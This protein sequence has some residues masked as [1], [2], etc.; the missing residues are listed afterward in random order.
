MMEKSQQNE[1]Q[2]SAESP[3]VAKKKRS[4]WRRFLRA[5]AHLSLGMLALILFIIIM[6]WVLL[7]TNPGLNGIIWTAEK[8]VPELKVED[9]E[10]ALLNDFQLYGI[11]YNNPD[12]FVA[13]QAEKLELDIQLRCIP[14]VELCI[15]TLGIE[16][17]NFALTDI[18]PS[19]EVA[20]EPPSEPI[21]SVSLPFGLGVNIERLYLDRIDLD[22][23]GNKIAWRE[24]ETGAQMRF[25]SLTL[26]PTRL[27]GGRL[28]LATSEGEP[29]VTQETSAD[30]PKSKIVLPEV[31]I[32]LSAK[33][34]DITV[35]DFKM[36]SPEVEIDR[37]HLIGSAEGN[38]VTVQTFELAMPLVDLNLDGEVELKEDYPL[39]INTDAKIKQTTLAGQTLS[40]NA[41][42]SVAD[43]ALSAGLRKLIVADIDAKLEPLDP[44]IPFDI[45]LRQAQVQ[46]PLQGEAD[47]KAQI[48]SLKAKGILD[49]YTLDLMG[50]VQGKAI[51][52]VDL[53]V[54]GEGSLEHIDLE[55]IDVKTL[56][57]A[58]EGSV[59][60]NWASPIN[61]AANLQ[62]QNI[63]PGSY[64]PEAEGDISGRL[65]T[66]GRLPEKGGWEV[67]LSELD[68]DGIFR[69]YPLNING[70]LDAKDATGKGDYRLDT[71]GLVVAHGQNN[72]RI[73]GN[74]DENWNLDTKLDIPQIKHTVP[75][76]DGSAIGL[77]ELRGPFA[78]P[79]VIA[80]VTANKIAW[81][82]Q[83]TIES[84]TLKG[85]VEPLPTPGGKLNLVVQGLQHLEQKV[86]RSEFSFSGTQEQHR[87]SFSLDSDIVKYMLDLSGELE[88]KPGIKWKGELL[89]S[90]L[91]TVQGEWALDHTPTISYDVDKQI[92]FVEAHC[93]LQADSKLCL[94]KDLEAGQSGEV[95]ASV[96]NFNFSQVAS[97]LP[98]DISL[99]GKVDAN[100]RA[101]WSPT[102]LPEV[103]VK[104]ELPKGNVT[105]K[106]DRPVTVGW[107]E[108]NLNASLIK[109]DL[110]AEWLIDLTNNG[111]I[112]GR[113][114]LDKV[115]TDNKQIDARL[116]L[117][118]ITLDMLKPLFGEFSKVGADINSDIELK[119]PVNQ[120]K[121]FGDLRVEN[122]I[123]TG[124]VSP[125]DVTSG[126]VI[127]KFSGYQS[128][129]DA[130]IETEDGALLITGESDWQDIE[131]W[132]AKYNISAN[133]LLVEVPPVVK[134]RIEP[135]IDIAVTPGLIDVKGEVRLPWGRI[136]VEELPPSAIS[137]SSDEVILDKDLKPLD[138]GSDFPFE[139]KSDIKVIIGD[140]FL[141]NA[142]G[143]QG[144]LVGEINVS[145]K[146][147]APF[148]LGEVNIVD[149]K[150]RSFGQDLIIDEGKVQFNG[151]AD[152]PYLSIKAIRNPDN[153]EDDVVA[154]IQVS[155]LADEPSIE[156][157][158]DPAMPQANALSYILRGQDIDSDSGG[159]AMT[160]AL[161]GLSLA[162]SGRV[163]GE[164][165][166][167]FGV[168]DLQLDTTGTGDDS[169]VTVSGYILPGLQVKY[170]V[171]IFE[172]VGE[173]TFRY[174]LM[175]DLYLEVMSGT[176]SAVDL[177]YQFE[178]D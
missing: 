119:G 79:E 15:K 80:D 152:Q 110:N 13:L 174:R 143:L 30:S 120:P 50:A 93:W 135:D 24:F 159:N 2:T 85:D 118:Q 26:N 148:I 23:L 84:I 134:A 74:L 70:V 101:K 73:S 104:V 9:T 157:F 10:G 128:N 60:A 6:L 175:K 168:S 124:D 59:M 62:L 7:F 176:D 3:P 92:A 136:T 18:A 52:D 151:P 77:I 112:K 63:Q 113:V 121:I 72:I 32:P 82:D 149:G 34:E 11:Q 166:E 25:D 162:R 117:Q 154:G 17:A 103:E 138:K 109:D 67:E 35:T 140:D 164:I 40:L 130:K 45:D 156:V 141:L 48:A 155:G 27:D 123:A 146:N 178:F 57:G 116:Q 144:G 37:A 54:D 8:F 98:K 88:T 122:I 22:I 142:F 78:T 115:S 76:L 87:A 91:E 89:E 145:Q 172:S 81:Q 170:G 20:N 49:N 16:G 165:G 64:W 65:A 108:A 75:D 125:I 153:T 44:D 69:D 137:V 107:N 127:A 99:V 97:L 94:D 139:I 39:T 133:Q 163:V 55:S 31:W 53:T 132:R 19:E 21:T 12:L 129:L 56:Q 68:I 28:T 43:L 58:I 106:L 71:P 14:K 177:L 61:W 4:L 158:S 95:F 161:I 126:Q 105:Q 100:A 167:A 96:Q 5:I 173:F 29:E 171:G 41:E 147:K 160:T 36:T 114:E 47:Y 46:W 33:I 150:Y 90:R 42:G 169:Q 102:A 83:V 131:D 86:T 66:T 51:P 38:N 111:D 1:Q